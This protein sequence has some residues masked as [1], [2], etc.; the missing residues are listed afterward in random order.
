M[1]A[2]ILP[3]LSHIAFDF[4][5]AQCNCGQARKLFGIRQ[6]AVPL[7][8]LVGRCRQ[9]TTKGGL[10]VGISG[11]IRKLREWRQRQRVGSG[12]EKSV[13]QVNAAGSVRVYLVC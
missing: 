12:R 1:T 4:M 11:C 13:E 10:W 2:D 6:E 5:S 7:C 9:Y 8:Q 3:R